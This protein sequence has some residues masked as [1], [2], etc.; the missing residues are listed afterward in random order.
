MVAIQRVHCG[1]ITG[2]SFAGMNTVATMR[3]SGTPTAIPPPAA[4]LYAVRTHKPNKP[5]KTPL[6]HH[7]GSYLTEIHH[8]YPHT[9]HFTA[10][11]SNHSEGEGGATGAVVLEV[12]MYGKG[13]I[14][15]T[16]YALSHPQHTYR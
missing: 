8:P 3:A 5:H 2:G 9:H 10:R 11:L 6:P 14:N 13:H 4:F 7:N 15:M 12:C 1:T 16:H